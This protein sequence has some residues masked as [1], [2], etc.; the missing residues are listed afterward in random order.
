VALSQARTRSRPGRPKPGRRW[1]DPRTPGI[2]TECRARNRFRRAATRIVVEVERSRFPRVGFWRELAERPEGGAISWSRLAQPLQHGSSLARD[3]GFPATIWSETMPIRRVVA[4]CCC[5]RPLWKRRTREH[6]RAMRVP[7]Q[8]SAEEIGAFGLTCPSGHPCPVYLE[9]AAV[10]SSSSRI[11]LTG[12]LH[13]ES[14]TLFSI[15]LASE[16]RARPGTSLTN[17][18]GGQGWSRSN[19]SISRTA[20]WRRATRR[21]PAR[22]VPA[23]HPRRRQV[24]ARAPVYEE[25]RAAL[26][27]SSISIRRPTG[28]CGWIGR[29]RASRNAATSCWRAGR[30][31]GV[32]YCA[33]RAGAPS[34]ASRPRRRQPLGPLADGGG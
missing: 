9:L 31:G 2:R 32:G 28:G 4:G 16:T 33:R 20:D 26:S 14:V 22:P 5:W 8:C 34:R 29:W 12:N 3:E 13:A 15:L 11:F 25:G 23:G 30:R 19:S 21:G 1:C 18:Y 10:G 27:T 17:G 24:V 7:F 6:G